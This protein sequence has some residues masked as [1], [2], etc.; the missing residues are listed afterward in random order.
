MSA[1]L[2]RPFQQPS[3]RKLAASSLEQ[4]TIEANPEKTLDSFQP[5]LQESIDMGYRI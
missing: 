3:D 1:T 4:A 5:R 2:G